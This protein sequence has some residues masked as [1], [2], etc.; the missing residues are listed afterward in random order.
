MNFLKSLSNSFFSRFPEGGM[1]ERGNI[2]SICIL[3]TSFPSN[4]LILF[5][6]ALI[7]TVVSFLFWIFFFFINSPHSR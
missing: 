4:L 2:P 5:L 7:H 6:P 1:P 3:C